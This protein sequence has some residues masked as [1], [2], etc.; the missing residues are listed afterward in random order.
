MNVIYFMA[1]FAIFFGGF[2][3]L[4]NAQPIDLNA[5]GMSNNTLTYNQDM[6]ISAFD[7]VRSIFSI[8]TGNS[9]LNTLLASAGILGVIAVL[10][11]ARG[12]NP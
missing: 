10:M 7:Y 12:I 11:Y 2:A 3:V 1:F 6:D 5:N 9:F 4:M 8:D